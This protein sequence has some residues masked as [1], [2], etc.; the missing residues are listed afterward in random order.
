[1]DSTGTK[2]YHQD[3][4]SNR[5]VTSST[6]AVL[7]QMG[8]FPFGESWYNA[9][10]D[11]LLFTTYERDAE[12]GN[13]YA[14]AR[15][16]IN[17]LSRFSS[18]DPAAGSTGDPQTLNGYL[19]TRDDPVDFV[20]PLG[21]YRDGPGQCSTGSGDPC[22]GAGGGGWSEMDIFAFAFTPTYYGE[23]GP[24][25]GNIDALDLIG[26]PG[27]SGFFGGPMDVSGL[28]RQAMV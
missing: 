18:A 7:A 3:Q 11:K 23:D 26:G 14:T 21:L 28:V 8:H 24:V 2:Y 1:I 19:Y 15:T 22:G 12:S 9:T 25:F 13:D 4:L 20:D 27:G 6:G 10:G 16:H 17:R 5:L